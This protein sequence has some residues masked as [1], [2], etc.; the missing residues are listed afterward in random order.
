MP[1]L[2]SELRNKLE[3]AQAMCED[4]LEQCLEIGDQYGQAAALNAIGRI[5]MGTGLVDGA[6]EYFTQAMGAYD[7]VGVLGGVAHVE[8]NLGVVAFQRGQ[9]GEAERRYRRA[10][11][12]SARIGDIRQVALL[13]TN[14]AEIAQ[15]AVRNA[16]CG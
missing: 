7:R 12:L 11:D 4:S 10:L 8:N 3:Q 6:V 14:I 15:M 9:W 2:V 5:L 1:T 16:V 13:N